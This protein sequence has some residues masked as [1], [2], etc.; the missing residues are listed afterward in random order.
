MVLNKIPKEIQPR[1]KVFL[2][3][4]DVYF[5]FLSNYGYKIKEERIATEYAVKYIVEIRYKNEELD[6]I[7]TVHYEPIDVFEKESDYLSVFLFNGIK[8]LN[9][10]LE[11]ELYIKKY[12]PELNIEHLTYP[13]KDNNDS[14]E[15]NINKSLAGFVY[16]LKDTGAKLIDGSEWEEGLFYDWSSA[17]KMLYKE[18][19]KRLDND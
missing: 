2:D 8:L 15:T 9:K 7:I 14:F 11:L 17:E 5:S 4:A 6:R 19:K 13:M 1:V 12:R 16:F 3:S 10:K 18:Q